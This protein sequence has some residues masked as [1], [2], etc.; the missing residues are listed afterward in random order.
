[1][2]KDYTSLICIIIAGLLFLTKCLVAKQL[3]SLKPE[4][5]VGNYAHNYEHAVMAISKQMLSI[6]GK[7]SLVVE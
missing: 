7:I 2:K 4:Q 3:D 5:Y 1:M 6:I